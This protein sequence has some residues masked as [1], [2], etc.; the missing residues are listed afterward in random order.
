VLDQA[1]DDNHRDD[2]HRQRSG[3]DTWLVT[4]KK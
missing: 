4:V 2:E 3:N 1:D